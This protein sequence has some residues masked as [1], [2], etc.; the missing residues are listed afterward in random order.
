MTDT[1]RNITPDHVADHYDRLTDVLD[2]ASEGNLHFGYWPA[3][4]DGS[5]VEVAAARLADHVIHKLGEVAGRR[6]LN[7]GC[8]SGKPAVRLALATPVDEVVGVTISPV[9]VDRATARAEREGVA[10]RVRFQRADAMQLPFPDDS[11]DA[12]WVVECLFHLHSP[13]QALGEIARVLRPGGRLAVMDIVLRE[14]IAAQ[15]REAYE[16]AA[17]MFAIPDHIELAE[18]PRLIS[19]A[20]LRLEELAD[21]GDDIIGPSHQALEAAALAK[22]DAFAAAFGVKSDQF[23]GHVAEFKR[24]GAALDLG[25]VVLTARRPG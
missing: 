17:S 10:D 9:Q 13:A 11:F 12:V 18:Y 19:G 2:E 7:V 3:P 24:I 16:R 15:E 22:P 21:L 5:S 4:H 8:D 6:V 14:P 23:D 20:G 25:Y 1:P